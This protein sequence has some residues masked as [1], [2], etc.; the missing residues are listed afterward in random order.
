V[1]KKKYT[2]KKLQKEK[3]NKAKRII[4]LKIEGMVKG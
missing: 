3:E 4:F 1:R 2:S